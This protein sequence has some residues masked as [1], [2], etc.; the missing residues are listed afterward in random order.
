MGTYVDRTSTV[1]SLVSVRLAEFFFS[2]LGIIE[3]VLFVCVSGHV[4]GER[5]IDAAT[6]VTTG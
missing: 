3:A 4:V 2:I 1:G 5:V 6:A